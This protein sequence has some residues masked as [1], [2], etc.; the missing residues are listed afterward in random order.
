MQR[1]KTLDASFGRIPIGDTAS[2]EAA[3]A[4]EAGRR[5][6]TLSGVLTD[7]RSLAVLQLQLLPSRQRVL[8]VAIIL[9]D[10][11]PRVSLSPEASNFIRFSSTV[12]KASEVQKSGATDGRVTLTGRLSSSPAG[13]RQRFA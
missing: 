7:A 1:M 13:G 3:R 8:T 5:A 11:L 6:L 12:R 4:E 2:G 9:R 10:P